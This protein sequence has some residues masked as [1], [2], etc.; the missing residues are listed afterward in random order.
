M[1]IEN[2]RRQ[3]MNTKDYGKEIARKLRGL[4]AENAL[5]Q[6][7]LADK[8]GVHRATII[9]YE[10]DASG[11]K[12]E[13]LKEILNLCNEDLYLFFKKL[14]DNSLERVR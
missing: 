8:M 5:S 10:T 13:T 3:N 1:V 14:Y 11:M 6:Q 2:R 9:K 12:L 7:E 4:R